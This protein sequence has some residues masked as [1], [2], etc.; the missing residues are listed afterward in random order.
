MQY[1][2]LKILGL[3]DAIEILRFEWRQRFGPCFVIV[4]SLVSTRE[5]ESGEI[6][7]ILTVW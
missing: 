6:K 1:S 3:K 5:H 4:M 7:N 2:F